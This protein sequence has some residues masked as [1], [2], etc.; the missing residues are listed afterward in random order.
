MA[1][2][3]K[4]D[5]IENADQAW[6]DSTNARDQPPENEA[7][8]GDR[9]KPGTGTPKPA[10]PVFL[11]STEIK[12]LAEEFSAEIELQYA[13][14]AEMQ[15]DWVRYLQLYRAKPKGGVKDYPLAHS[16]NVVVRIIASFTDQIVARAMQGIFGPE[17]HW[18]VQELNKKWAPVCKPYERYLDW[19]RKF[20]WDQ[21]EV[22]HNY[23]LDCVKL[24]TAIG[25]DDFVDEPMF[26]YDD[27]EHKTVETG[28]KKGPKP[29]WVPREDFLIPTGFPDLQLAPW[30]AHR[31]WYSWDRLERLA[32]QGLIQNLDEIRGSSDEE[33]EVKMERRKNRLE[34]QDS[35]GDDRFGLWSPWWVWFRRDLDQDGWPEEYVMLLHS[36]QREVLRLVSNPSPSGKRPYFTS[37]FIRVQGQFD[38][39]GVPEQLESL[40]DE[41]STIHNQRRDR[42]H[43][44]NI[45]MYIARAASG[46]P[47]T[48]RPA[49][50]KV[51]KTTDP[52][53]IKEFHPATNVPIDI[54]EEDFVMKLAAQFVGMND[55]DMGKAS[56]PVG[57]AAATTIMALMQE[58]ARRFDLNVAGIRAALSE[59]GHQITELWQIYGLPDA[60]EAG[61]PEQV[62]D[63]NEAQLVRALIEQPANLR[64]LI[65]IQLNVSTAA[66]NREVE[67]QSNMQLYQTVQQYMMQMIQLAQPLAN[68]QVPPELKA[69]MIHCIKGQD[70]LLEKIFQSFNAMDLDTVLAGDLF[71]EMA[72]RSIQ[73]G[74]MIQQAQQQMGMIP[75]AAQQG[76]Q[77]QPSTANGRPPIQ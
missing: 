34:M 23:T 7:P 18:L 48:I 65:N 9:L 66:V 43:L 45:V 14:Q 13:N 15:R 2:R 63:E 55:V 47:D 12:S 77:P 50:G 53:D 6:T 37:P 3:R 19:S 71:E 74:Q 64:G 33:D 28:R 10:I 8:D 21:R 11:S 61:S 42:A 41:S 35:S 75:G 40:Q 1:R 26:R 54:Q 59:Q 16:S 39:I 76:P 4:S 25:Y 36:G 68:P 51:I 38:G 27:Q 56:S 69:A 22:I 31:V 49:S 29:I 60:E 46:V 17:P 32:Y 70:K 57:R 58:G 5:P 62:L 24:G 44:A 72:Q 30:C 67:K 20:M 52:T 73:Q